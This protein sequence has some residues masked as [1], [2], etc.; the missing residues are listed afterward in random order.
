MEF[1]NRRIR[2]VSWGIL[3]LMGDQQLK[4][5]GFF[6]DVGIKE[7]SKIKCLDRGINSVS[8]MVFLAEMKS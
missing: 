7:R 6:K 3:R 5:L 1:W 8:K 2:G 4:K